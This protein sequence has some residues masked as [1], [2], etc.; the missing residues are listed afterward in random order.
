MDQLLSFY[1]RLH[2]DACRL[3]A[4]DGHETTDVIREF[5]RW[6]R[7]ARVALERADLQA[8]VSDFNQTVGDGAPWHIQLARLAG[9]VDSARDCLE[10]GMLGKLRHIL[11]VEMFGSVLEQSK[12]LLAAG[13]RIPA[14]VLGR[15]VIEKWLRDQG[16]KAGIPNWESAGASAVN[17][18]LRRTNVYPLP[19]GRLMQH[20]LDIGNAAAH[21]KDNEFTE[22]DV[23]RMIEFAEATCH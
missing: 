21:G 10:S 1:Y 20:Y 7:N 11:H 13:H 5:A 3:L 15:I 23:H 6:T 17:D 14:A 4:G 16:E 22:E 2:E 9:I 18:A 19:K 12:G 8:Y